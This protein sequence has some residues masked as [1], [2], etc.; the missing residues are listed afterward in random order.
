MANF[1]LLKKNAALTAIVMLSSAF[2][3]QP[4]GILG[5]QDSGGGAYAALVSSTGIATP[6]NL[7][8]TGFINSIAINGFGNGIIGGQDTTG[9]SPPYAAII[10][11]SGI[12]TPINLGIINGSIFA[13]AINASGQGLIG[14]EDGVFAY[15]A[16][17]SPSGIATP[18]NTGLQAASSPPFQSTSLVKGSLG[19]KT[20]LLQM[21]TLPS[22]PL[23]AQ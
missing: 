20:I 4:F 2:A 3:E 7:G 18:I 21:L 13:V 5:G 19:E 17:V 14:G 16:F 15:A 22:L 6:I 1:K 11:S 23:P 12:A 8:I 9:T 10:S